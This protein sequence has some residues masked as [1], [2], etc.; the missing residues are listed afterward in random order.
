MRALLLLNTRR[1]QKRCGVVVFVLLAVISTVVF[2]TR[3]NAEDKAIEKLNSFVQAKP[4]S[5]A[6]KALRAGRDQI[7][8]EN[9]QQ[10][11]AG[12]QDF[13]REHPK[14]RDVDAALYWLAYALKKQDKKDEAK[15]H[16]LRVIREFPKSS[17]AN[18]SRAML[19]ELGFADEARVVLDAQRGDNENCEMKILA[20]QSLFEADEEKAFNF[21]SDLLKN[22]SP[23]CPA[24]RTAAVSLLGGEGGPRAAP[25][26]LDIARTN[27]DLKLRLT[28]IRTPW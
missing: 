9:W 17:W 18:E 16:L 12:F 6:A 26:L 5:P 28:A 2:Y 13:L 22:P 10:A 19:V 11:V 27:P 7:E 23:S 8:A 15:P 20:L 21:V 24:L 1:S 25:I 14:A 4:D 3:A